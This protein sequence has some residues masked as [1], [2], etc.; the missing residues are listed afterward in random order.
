LSVKTLDW[1]SRR[2]ATLWREILASTPLN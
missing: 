2:Q 1:H